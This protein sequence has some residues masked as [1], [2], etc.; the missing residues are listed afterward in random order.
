MLI[1]KIGA[2]R[3]YQGTAVPAV[4]RAPGAPAG[5]DV[6][7]TADKGAAARFTDQASAALTAE[8]LRKEHPQLEATIEPA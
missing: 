1:L 7:T 8:R 6:I 4:F 2:D 3:Y 5:P